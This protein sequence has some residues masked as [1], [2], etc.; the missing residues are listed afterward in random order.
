MLCRAD[1]SPRGLAGWQRHGTCGPYGV[2]AAAST[3]AS[4]AGKVRDVSLW[5]YLS[6]GNWHMVGGQGV[7]GGYFIFSQGNQLQ[8]TISLSDRTQKNMPYTSGRMHNMEAFFSSLYFFFF[9]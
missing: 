7:G 4:P 3:S 8:A 5:L 1:S 2:A 6:W 9:F